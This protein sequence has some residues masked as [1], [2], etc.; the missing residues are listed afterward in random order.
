MDRDSNSEA[1]LKTTRNPQ[2]E[3]RRIAPKPLTTAS[4][5]A[6][7]PGKS[8]ADG[9]IRPGFGSLKIRKRTINGGVACEWI[10][11]WSREGKTT[12]Q[13]IGRY[14]ANEIP[15]FL[16]LSQAR[17][18]A[19][20]LQAIIKSG[21][22]P[23]AQR[24]AERR[25]NMKRLEVENARRTHAEK[26]SLSYLLSIYVESLIKRK[27]FDSAYDVQ[28]IFKN[29]IFIPFPNIACLPAGEVTPA[30][31]NAILAR[32]V[33]ED[34]KVKKGRT[35]LKLRSYVHAAYKMAV[36]ANLDPTA[37]QAANEFN[38]SNNPVSVI[39]ATKMASLYNRKR[40]R[41]LT[42]IEFYNYLC[43]V[44]TLP[45]GLFKLALQ[46]QIAT[47]GQRMK[48][49]LRLQYVDV[50]I[51]FLELYDPKG[52]RMISRLHVLPILPEVDEI[53]KELK[54]INPPKAEM[55]EGTPLFSS[56]GSV[57][58]LES[59]SGVVKQISDWMVATQTAESP[60]RAGDIRRTVETI[61]AGIVGVTKDTRAQLLSHG[62]SGVQDNVY[63]QS[64]YLP[65]KKDAMRV[66]NDY[67]N[68][69]CIGQNL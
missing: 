60:F 44:A 63:D 65:A 18:E 43:N 35:A 25:A 50:K 54:S 16:T 51:D 20:R 32:L 42:E 4:I 30:H 8:I 34:V 15:N 19:S 66:W 56:R 53:L 7:K 59:I 64:N 68:D 48:Q 37:P 40:K 57:V 3:I 22:S 39:S 36:N 23:I 11:E 28:N 52:K 67:V 6:L 10:F 38:F 9:A 5:N 69:L 47:C 45:E 29:H 41:Y 55:E 17:T 2:S 33:G 31:I 21:E 58:A 26:N 61:L 49:L 46:L 62:I 27:K 14:S 12:R 24:D 1:F 13:T